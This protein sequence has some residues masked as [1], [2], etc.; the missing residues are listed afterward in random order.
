LYL[1]KNI[2][3]VLQ[4]ALRILGISAPEEMAR[5]DEEEV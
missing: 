4:N 2:Q 1:L 5:E 3:I